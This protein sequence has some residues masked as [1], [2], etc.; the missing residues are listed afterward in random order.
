MVVEKAEIMRNINDINSV[1]HAEK[2]SAF[3]LRA[4]DRKQSLEMNEMQ[5]IS[6]YFTL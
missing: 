4:G 1:F 5:S 6:C 3:S 2:F